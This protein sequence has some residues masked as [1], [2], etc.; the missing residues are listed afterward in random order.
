MDAESGGTRKQN[1]IPGYT[2]HVRSL[3]QISGRTHGNATSRA[4]NV[5]LREIAVTSPIPSAPH[6]N[7]KISQT[8]PADTFVT[9]TFQGKVYQVPGYTGHVPNTRYSFA[10]TY[11]TVTSEE[12]LKFRGTPEGYRAPSADRDF[13]KDGFAKTVYP[14]QFIT[15]D[16]QSLSG[17]VRTAQAPELLIP[18]HLRYVRFFAH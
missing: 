8:S 16:S 13:G 2:G 5:D 15:L 11:G 14:R 12:M 6:Q 18:A 1:L 10:Q 17:G 3:R 4:L 9:N 7:R